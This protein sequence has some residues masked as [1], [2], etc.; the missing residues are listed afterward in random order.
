MKLS[1]FV[2]SLLTAAV[3]Y[4]PAANA[5]PSFESSSSSISISEA[6]NGETISFA[7]TAETM[8]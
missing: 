4:A 6:V 3:I 7:I 8:G 5:A 2:M 1:P